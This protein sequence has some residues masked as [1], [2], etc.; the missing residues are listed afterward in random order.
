MTAE[1]DFWL[2]E[3]LTHILDADL[4]PAFYAWRAHRDAR[5]A[6]IVRRWE[7]KKWSRSFTISNCLRCG[8]LLVNKDKR[9]ICP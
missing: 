4:L 7:S 1:N 2:V 8:H 5:W 6:R 9:H 3:A